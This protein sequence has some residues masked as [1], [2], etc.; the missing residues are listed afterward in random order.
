MK[1]PTRILSIICCLFVGCNHIHEPA[2]VSFYYWRTVFELS[3]IE[4]QTLQ[5]NEVSK[6]YVRYFDVDMD[7]RAL[8]ALR[9]PSASSR[10]LKTYALYP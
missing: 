9:V 4:R 5:E 10:S 2:A 1:N 7:S 3:D 6:M 8:L